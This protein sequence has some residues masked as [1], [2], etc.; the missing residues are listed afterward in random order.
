MAGADLAARNGAPTL[1]PIGDLGVEDLHDAT[2]R[3]TMLRGTG[4]FGASKV[5]QASNDPT[6]LGAHWDCDGCVTAAG[7]PVVMAASKLYIEFNATDDDIGVH[8]AFDD[9]RN[10]EFPADLSDVL[11]RVAVFIDRRPGN[12]AERFDIGEAGQDVI[13]YSVREELIFRVRAAAL[14]GQNRDR[15]P[16][17]SRDRIG[18][19][20]SHAGYVKRYRH[21]E[22]DSQQADNDHIHAAGGPR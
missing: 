5:D 16:G 12:Y 8:G 10:T 22:G 3:F 19:T 6:T 17:G 9:G 2:L 18:F 1:R 13:V 21:A 11:G 4:L 14:E 20:F 15:V 7:E